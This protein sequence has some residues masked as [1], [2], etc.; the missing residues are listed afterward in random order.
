MRFDRNF[1][2]SYCAIAIGMLLGGM[3]VAS[4]E[5]YGFLS[6]P[7]I[8]VGSLGVIVPLSVV[9]VRLFTNVKIFTTEDKSAAFVQKL[10]AEV[11]EHGGKIFSTYLLEK[12][13]DEDFVLKYL[14]NTKARVDYRRLFM[15]DDPKKEKKWIGNFLAQKS[16]KLFVYLHVIRRPSPLFAHFAQL[17]LPRINLFMVE[18]GELIKHRLVLISLLPRLCTKEGNVI[19]IAIAIKRHDVYERLY[20]YVEILLSRSGPR[21]AEI[22]SLDAYIDWI[23]RP[24]LRTLTEQAINVTEEMAEQE[25]EIVHVGVFG[26]VGRVCRKVVIDKYSDEFENDLDLVIVIDGEESLEKVKNTIR[27]RLEALGENV[28][29]E[30]SNESPQFYYFREGYEIDVQIHVK[31]DTYY[32]RNPLLGYSIFD[33]YYVLY[34]QNNWPI[35]DYLDIPSEVVRYSERRKFFLEDRLGLNAFL[36]EC[37]SGDVRIDPRRV[38]SINIRNLVWCLTG[39]WPVSF[40]RAIQFSKGYLDES[41][42]GKIEAISKA[43]D[44]DIKKAQKD[45]MHECVEILKTIRYIVKFGNLETT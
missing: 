31:G 13:G 22:R 24:A 41:V 28:K 44:S 37:S 21:V 23:P 6:T 35:S 14:K 32:R 1:V 11:C 5:Q 33:N 42:C 7:L 36:R 20:D 15:I 4:S 40:R 30:W 27:L 26:S 25:L 9:V 39:R 45:F 16:D 38:I 17:V 3:S 8:V 34:S 19:G 18:Y 12:S 29:V 10:L 2:I 43:S